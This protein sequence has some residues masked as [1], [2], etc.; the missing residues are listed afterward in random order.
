MPYERIDESIVSF[1]KSIVFTLFI[2]VMLIGP[3]PIKR[4]YIWPNFY[5]INKKRQNTIRF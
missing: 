5:C 4:K 3:I 2:P 1:S